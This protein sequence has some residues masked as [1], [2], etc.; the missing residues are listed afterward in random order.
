VATWG[1]LVNRTLQSAYKNFGAVPEPGPLTEADRKL[2]E[3]IEA[4]FES[5]GALIEAARFKN[6]LQETM[7]LASLGNQYVAEQAP[8]AILESD[9]ER[10]GTVL[11][12]ALRTIDNL[13]ILLTPFLPFSS[14][15]LHE[16]LGYDDVL[17]GPLDLRTIE[18]AESRRHVVLTGDYESW[19]GRWEAS[20]LPVGQGLREPAPLF[21]KLDPDKVVADELARMEAAAAA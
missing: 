9:R 2:L 14:Q 3:E 16:L 1:N 10:A 18:E 20:A 21:T 11:Y 4:G 7:R 8:W 6:A 5:V 19:A 13:K 15:R 12:V 17:A